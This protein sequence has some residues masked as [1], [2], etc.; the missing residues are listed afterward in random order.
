MGAFA[1]AVVSCTLSA[2]IARHASSHAVACRTSIYPAVFPTLCFVPLLRTEGYSPLVRCGHRNPD[3]PFL[4][5]YCHTLKLEASQKAFAL[6]AN[7][8]IVRGTIETEPYFTCAEPHRA[9][10]PQTP[11]L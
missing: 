11:D 7:G 8:W 6:A 9:D 1:F 5:S 2:Y 10:A 3:T 4:R